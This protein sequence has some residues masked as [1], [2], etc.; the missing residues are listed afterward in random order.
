MYCTKGASN[1]QKCQPE[2]GKAMHEWAMACILPRHTIGPITPHIIPAHLLSRSAET[3]S[4][5]T[6][7][8]H[9]KPVTKEG[10]KTGSGCA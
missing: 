4:A 3:G 6:A 2:L 8:T 10:E 7:R 1:A 5:A 9:E